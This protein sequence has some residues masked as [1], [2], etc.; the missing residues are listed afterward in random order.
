MERQVHKQ[1]A[2][3]ALLVSATALLVDWLASA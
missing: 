3:V 2:L 1:I